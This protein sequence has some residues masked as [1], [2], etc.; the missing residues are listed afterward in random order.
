MS[1]SP[2]SP[3]LR[4]SARHFSL[5][6]TLEF[7]LACRVEARSVAIVWSAFASLRRDSPESFRGWCA[8][9]DLNLQSFRNQILSLARLPFR[10]ARNRHQIAP[11][12]A[13]SQAWFCMTVLQS[14]SAHCPLLRCQQWSADLRFGAFLRKFNTCRAGGRR[15]KA[16]CGCARFTARDCA[17]RKVCLRSGHVILV[18]VGGRCMRGVACRRIERLHAVGAKPVERGKR[19]AFRSGQKPRQRHGFSRRD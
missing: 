3:A 15:S 18:Q 5:Y 17:S 12:T 9:E 19:A 4:D 1:D 11:R 2:P 10:H 16:V 13:E 7:K 6:T 14:T 8:R